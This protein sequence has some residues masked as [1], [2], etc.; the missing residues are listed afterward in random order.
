VCDRKIEAFPHAL[1][2]AVLQPVGATG[3]M[4]REDDLVGSEDPQR[5]LDRLG[6]V[7]VSDTAMGVDPV[8]LE[9]G[10]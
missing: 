5:I 6:R 3:G 10:E 7:V 8:G 1:D 2:D 4:G 9:S